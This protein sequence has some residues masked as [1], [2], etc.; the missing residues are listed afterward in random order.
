MAQLV[1]LT[2]AQAALRSITLHRLA[3]TYRTALSPN[4]PRRRVLGYRIASDPA[5]LFALG[6]GIPTSAALA[7]PPTICARVTMRYAPWEWARYRIWAA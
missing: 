4:L 3:P 2:Y 5:R 6:G 7:G 1:S